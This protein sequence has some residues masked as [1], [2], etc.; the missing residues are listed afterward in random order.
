MK[1]DAS[2]TPIRP[3]ELGGCCQ[4]TSPVARCSSRSSCGA[5]V[6]RRM[7]DRGPVTDFTDVPIAP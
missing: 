7:T 6:A 2:P 5:V 1:V 3:S 4:S